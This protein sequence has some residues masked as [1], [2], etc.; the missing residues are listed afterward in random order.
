VLPIW[1]P[2]PLPHFPSGFGLP[3]EYSS[4]KSPTQ[5]GHGGTETPVWPLA[6]RPI[7]MKGLSHK[8]TLR[9]ICPRSHLHFRDPCDTTPAGT[10]L[11]TAGLHCYGYAWIAS[12]LFAY[13]DGCSDPFTLNTLEDG[14][15]ND[16]TLM[17]RRTYGASACDPAGKRMRGAGR[18]GGAQA[19]EAI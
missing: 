10:G 7:L 12:P 11:D 19:L 18:G 3:H 1:R 15:G 17:Y 13:P 2:P 14:E 5:R 16:S 9:D 6:I 4:L 8:T